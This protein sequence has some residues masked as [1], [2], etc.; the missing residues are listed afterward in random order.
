MIFVPQTMPNREFMKSLTETAR[1]DASTLK[2]YSRAGEVS[3][4]SI[5]QNLRKAVCQNFFFHLPN[6]CGICHFRSGSSCHHLVAPSLTPHG[7]N[8]F[9]G[10]PALPLPHCSLFSTQWQSY[11][12]KVYTTS[13]HFSVQVHQSL[14][15]FK[16]KTTIF[17]M[18]FYN[19]LSVTSE[20]YFSDLLGYCSSSPSLLRVS[21][22]DVQPLWQNLEILETIDK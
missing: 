8:L 7:N 20:G 4:N 16:S 2:T 12:I 1:R 22:R 11:P 3:M 19:H 21:L 6:I 13:G 18:P 9:T 15:R 5:R 17:V 14:H 10:P